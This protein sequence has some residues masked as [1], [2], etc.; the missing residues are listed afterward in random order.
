MPRARKI[1]LV[2]LFIAHPSSTVAVWMEALRAI[3]RGW[4]HGLAGAEPRN[5][6]EIWT[7]AE[8][9]LQGPMIG[10]SS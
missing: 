7:C 9:P 4:S 1:H 8:T 5:R 6:T 10:L 2:E 3:I